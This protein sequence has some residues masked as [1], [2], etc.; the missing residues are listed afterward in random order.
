MR[1]AIGIDIGGTHIRAATVSAEGVILTRLTLATPGTPEAVFKEVSAFIARLSDRTTAAIGIG[2]PGRVDA[3]S[4]KIYSGGFVDLSDQDLKAR[5]AGL[6]KLPVAIDNDASMALRAEA[7]AGAARGLTDVALLTIG[8]GIGGAIMAGGKIFHGRATA[9]QLG[10]LTVDVQGRSCLCGRRGCVETVSSGTALSRHLSEA[11]LDPKTS[12]TT[13]L[14]GRDDASRAV[15]ERWAAPLRAAIDSLVATL[16]PQC[17]VLGGGLGAAACQALAA[18]PA[19]SPWYQCAVVP[20]LLG[21]DAGVIGAG[22]AGLEQ[23]A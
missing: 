9:G 23:Q 16:D 6:H 21:D 15:L 13:L 10:H 7:R 1:Y 5:L 14:Q 8:T 4:S 20:A 12:I 17:V 19:I 18:F 3:T 2:I 11:G 22:L